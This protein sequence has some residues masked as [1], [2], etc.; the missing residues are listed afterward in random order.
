MTIYT[1]GYTG[2]KIEDVQ[3]AVDKVNGL[4]VDVRMMPRSRNPIW[5]STSLAKR[6]PGQYLWLKQFGNR[7]YKAGPIEIV[8]FEAGAATLLREIAGSG[9]SPVLLCGC[10]DVNICHRKILAEWLGGL[11]QMEIEHLALGALT[12]PENGNVKGQQRLF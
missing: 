4:L 8:N 9:K 11:W 1:L 5:N 7:N 12:A 6:L 10:S 3:A 2:W